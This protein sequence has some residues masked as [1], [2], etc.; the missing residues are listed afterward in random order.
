MG[1]SE[2]VLPE[3]P[4]AKALQ[5]MTKPK[6]IAI[7]DSFWFELLK[8]QL[9]GMLKPGFFESHY[10]EPTVLDALVRDAYFLQ[11]VATNE[12][13]ANFRTFLR[14]WARLLHYYRTS[15]A[16]AK[17]CTFSAVLS[18]SL[19]CRCLLKQFA[20]CFAAHE[21]L[22][23]LEQ[24]PLHEDE[25]SVQEGHIPVNYR[26]KRL[27]VRWPEQPSEG[28][29]KSLLVE[30]MCALCPEDAAALQESCMLRVLPTGESVSMLE[31]AER[32]VEAD[33]SELVL[34]P[35]AVP[36]YQGSV[37]RSV[38]RELADFLVC[39]TFGAMSSTPSVQGEEDDG[40]QRRNLSMSPTTMR[41]QALLYEI[42]LLLSAVVAATAT[43]TG[44]GYRSTCAPLVF[45][46][47]E[48]R[49]A[50]AAFRLRAQAAEAAGQRMSS[51]S[52]EEAGNGE[53][54]PKLPSGDSA[55][56]PF[57][58][59]L[60]EVLQEEAEEVGTEESNGTR[61]GTGTANVA[62]P[63]SSRAKA[64]LAT[65]LN[66]VWLEPHAALL[67]NPPKEVLSLMS[68]NPADPDSA[69]FRGV[70]VSKLYLASSE[71]MPGLPSG[72]V[73]DDGA[74]VEAGS[75]GK[76]LSKR[77]LLVLLLL[78]FHSPQDHPRIAQ[79]FASLADPRLDQHDCAYARLAA[80][81]HFPKILRALMQK[82]P[83]PGY[84]LLLYC[85]VIKNSN[86]RKYCQRNADK[87]LPSIL[88][89][90]QATTADSKILAKA[91]PTALAL[92]LCVLALSGDGGFCQQMSE[93]KMLDARSVLGA[94]QRSVREITLSS[95]LILVL[96]RLAHWN[97]GACRDS[98][99]NQAIAST[100]GNLAAHGVQNVHWHTANRM[101]E[102]SGLLARNLVKLRP[103]LG[104]GSGGSG[105]LAE[106]AELHRARM[107]QSLLRTLLRLVSG[108]LRVPR[109][110][111]N[112]QLVYALQK[113]YPS[114]F[115][116][117][118]A[119]PELGPPLMHVRTATDW[120]EAQCPPSEEDGVEAQ[121]ERL[122]EASARLPAE[123]MTLASVAGASVSA[124]AETE[125][126]SA[127]FLPAVWDAAQKLMPEH[128]CWVPSPKS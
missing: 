54:E 4:A 87:V 43:D 75:A 1:S 125:E 33:V 90:L 14:F 52:Q 39:S 70:E 110:A 107:V 10:A 40:E 26:G 34:C 112:T 111:A 27:Q 21:L 56:L 63:D 115:T 59:A 121:L 102:V 2:S 65:L 71:L 6:R 74:A 41:L 69:P 109:A 49:R 30:P 108:C 35:T 67:P 64:F 3:G 61:I 66:I 94:S 9:P 93:V 37:L 46:A 99:F 45:A 23:Q 13:S 19:L 124:Y 104:G 79:A 123:L 50:E 36:S 126:V 42:L 80:P 73:G 24:V 116:Q 20:E 103:A 83:E 100:L 120:F 82:L 117:L 96:L 86:F 81:L 48:R 28:S 55:K 89:V 114:Q 31:A 11:L 47:A 53:L 32:M 5:E 88:E 58:Q 18:L 25:A 84:P 91:P 122:K 76:A 85:L 62:P 57:L 77:A 98:F 22:F 72:F 15:P 8:V 106:A 29:L 128:V 16:D 68:M 7:T 118:E 38:F 95:L 51:S 97:F 44:T 119:D 101:L 60:L 12:H 105:G 113:D 78:L 17:P 127:Y 92:L